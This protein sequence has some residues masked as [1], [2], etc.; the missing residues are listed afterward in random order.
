LLNTPKQAEG[1][2]LCPWI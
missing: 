1:P 2:P